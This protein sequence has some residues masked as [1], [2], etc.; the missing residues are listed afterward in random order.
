MNLT[1]TEPNIQYTVFD[2]RL[3]NMQNELTLGA[4]SGRKAANEARLP[5]RAGNLKVDLSCLQ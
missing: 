1:N 4:G 3:T 5:S 2:V